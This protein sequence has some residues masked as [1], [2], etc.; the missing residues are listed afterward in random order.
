M[1][2]TNLL[3]GL[4]LIAVVLTSSGCFSAKAKNIQAFVKPHQVNVTA[5]QFI[6]QPPDEI[7][8]HCVKVPEINLQRQQIRSDGRVSFEGLGDVL[9][10]GLTPEQLAE[11][12]RDR[13][14]QLY[15]LPGGKPISVRVSAHRSRLYY[16]LG[17]VVQP[18]PKLFTGRDS[19][20]TAVAA[21]HP[22]ITGWTKHI[23]VIRP[24]AD[25]AVKPKVFEVNFN[26]MMVHGDL[27]KNVLLQEGDIIYIP[28]TPLAAVAMVVEEFVRPIGRALSPAITVQQLATPTN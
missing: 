23:Q 21:A 19:V 5:E 7:E 22:A 28:P 1:R 26:R 18:G 14:S 13:A 9:A 2:R 15:T 6:L 4:L 11:V 20:L 27:S 10:A 8:V 17:Q 3:I 24:S 12:L 16:V 25:M